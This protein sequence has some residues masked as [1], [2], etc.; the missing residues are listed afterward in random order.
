V[1]P[2]TSRLPV[3][4]WLPEGKWSEVSGL[5]VA[6]KR[7]Q[8]PHVVI[9]AGTIRDGDDGHGYPI[10]GFAASPHRHDRILEALGERTPVDLAACEALQRDVVDLAAREVRDIFCRALGSGE[11]S[12]GSPLAIAHEILDR[13]DSSAT[14]SS[15]AAALLY[16]TVHGQVLAELFPESRY[17]ALTRRGRIVWPTAIR[18]LTASSSPWF[19][20][21]AERDQFARSVLEKSAADLAQRF[22]SDPSAWTWGELHT[23]ELAHPLAPQEG[24]SSLVP[25]WA[26]PGS[27]T[28]IL[29]HVSEG[30]SLPLSVVLAPM[31]RMV[32]DLSVPEA[33]FALATGQSGRIGNASLT[34]QV[35]AWQEGRYL[36]ISLGPEAAATGD[37]TELIAG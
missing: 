7:E 2:S 20:G 3:R 8:D 18:I 12:S 15:G 37:I 1:R 9:A 19:A 35:G 27:T 26:A 29:Q 11:I 14:P 30:T 31:V 6:T 17:G 33:R 34:D 22:G 32:T 16:G 5:S 25:P 23:L 21:E 28:T 24:F 36:T 10:W 13:W 4:G